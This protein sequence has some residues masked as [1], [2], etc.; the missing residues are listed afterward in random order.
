MLRGMPQTLDEAA[1]TDW[2]PAGY[3][4]MQVE[5]A[6][7]LRWIGPLPLVKAAQI[8]SRSDMA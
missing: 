5:A 7:A 4:M 8:G 2:V 6:R 1:R 3:G